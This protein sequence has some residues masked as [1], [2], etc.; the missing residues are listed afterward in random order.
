MTIA[1][2]ILASTL[3]LGVAISSARA[4]VCYQLSPFIDVIR[5]AQLKSADET[6]EAEHR[7]VFGNWTAGNF[8]SLPVV[9]SVDVDVPRASPL[10]YRVT[11]HGANNIANP[12]DTGFTDCTLNGLLGGGWNYTCVGNKAGLFNSSGASF[13]QISCDTLSSVQNAPGAASQ[14]Q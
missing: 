2:T 13:T 6:T 8:Y 3:A 5:L 11:L 9:G 4:E 14:K 10:K 12:N 7:L 1:K